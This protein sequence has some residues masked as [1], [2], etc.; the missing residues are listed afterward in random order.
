M[1]EAAV[2]ILNHNGKKYLEQFLPSVVQ[3]SAG[4]Q[5]I[6]ADN[7]STDGSVELIATLFPSVQVIL[8]GRNEGFSKGYNL[9]LQQ[10][11]AQY[12]ILLNSDVEVTPSWLIPLLQLMNSD[13]KIGAC[14]PKIKYYH[15]KHMFEYAGAAGG[16]ID[17]W[18]YPFC[19]GRIFT[20]L[21]EDNRQYDDTREVFWAS[22][23]CMVVRAE[24][25]WKTGGLDEYFFAHM[26]EIDLCWRMKNAG[27][28]IYACGQSEVYH[29]GGGTLP[30][31]NPRKTFLNFRN[32][33]VLL[34][35][36]LPAS[37][38]L[39]VIF[40]RLVLDGIAA[41]K[42]LIS[43][44]PRDFL[45]V[46][47]AHFNFYRYFLLWRSRRKQGIPQ[48]HQAGYAQMYAGSVVYA[49]FV[50]KKKKFSELLF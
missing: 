30:K 41:L 48:T 4:S 28:T 39:S 31:S 14:Q 43:D 5:V 23:A 11:Q 7:G 45:A 3:Y 24:A 47:G 32:G 46:V 12:Y 15:Q 44:S 16:F 2:V 9:A 38:L 19:R 35:K 29:I 10:I 26:E 17:K 22:G 49:F 50:E 13:S 27:Y 20:S 8:L 6:V 1:T 34:Y 40:I 36:N 21:E 33:L 25:Y 37:Q 18:G 42:F